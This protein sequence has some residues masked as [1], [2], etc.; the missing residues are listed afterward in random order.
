M[1][2]DTATIHVRVRMDAETK[3]KAKAVLADLGLSAS[4]AVRM[5]FRRIAADGNL[6]IELKVPNARTR[7]A[8]AESN[9]LMRAKIR[10]FADADEALAA[11]EGPARAA[12]H[13]GF[14][15]ARVADDRK[16]GR[17]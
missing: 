8:I 7:R 10:R 1:S 4:D 13:R 17:E 15:G 12:P 14:A 2:P 3:R 11:H 16:G 9:E 6:P 5:L